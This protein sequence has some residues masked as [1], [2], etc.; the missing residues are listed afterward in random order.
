MLLSS[1][2]RLRL[3][4][5]GQSESLITNNTA[6]N[7]VLQNWLGSVSIDIEGYLCRNLHIEART[8]YFDVEYGRTQYWLSSFPVV[9]LTDIYEDSLGLWEGDESQIDDPVN[10]SATGRVILPYT[11]S[12]VAAKA[13]RVCYTGGLA[14]DAVRSVMT[15][16]AGAGTFVAERY[17]IGSTS[18]AVGIVVSYSSLSLTVE[19]YY[20]KFSTGETLVQ[21]DDEGVTATTPAVTG[22]LSAFAQESLLNA[23]PNIVLACEAQIRYMR[24]HQLDFEN[25]GTQ[26]DGVTIR[27]GN[28]MHLKF[29]LR[30]EV[31]N[32]LWPYVRTWGK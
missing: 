31:L 6:N 14:Y 9:T 20:G 4:C 15:L 18:G 26:K 30:E 8:E 16:A 10:D 3:Y 27:Q 13:L 22:T 12:F 32:M 2:R 7:R 11:L 24:Q 28:P 29:P 25:S 19:Q 21:Y 1:L 17:V 23:Y 5:S